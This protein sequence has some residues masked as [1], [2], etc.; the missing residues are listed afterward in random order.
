MLNHLPLIFWRRCVFCSQDFKNIAGVCTDTY[1]IVQELRQSKNFSFT[2]RIIKIP[3]GWTSSIMVELGMILDRFVQKW[4]LNQFR[5][6]KHTVYFSSGDAEEVYLICSVIPEE[7]YVSIAFTG[8]RSENYNGLLT[9]ALKGL[10]HRFIS[11][12]LQDNDLNS[13]SAE[14]MIQCLE[15]TPFLEELNI[16]NNCFFPDNLQQLTPALY[17][18]HNL[19]DLNISG[20]IIHVR[21]AR[22]LAPALSYMTGLLRLNMSGTC[23]GHISLNIISKSIM[24]MTK[25]EYLNLSS[26]WTGE[27]S[28]DDFA[29]MLQSLPALTD[30]DLSY[31]EIG[32]EKMNVLSP[33]ICNGLTKLKRLNLSCN[34][35]GKYFETPNSVLTISTLEFLN[36]SLNNISSKG[37]SSLA[38]SLETMT[39][40]KELNLRSNVGTEGCV[41][42]SSPIKKMKMLTTLDI[43]YNIESDLTPLILSL[44]SLPSLTSLNMSCNE[45]MS[46][47]H[48]LR[49]L[50]NLLSLNISDNNLGE[51]GATDLS[52]PLSNMTRLTSLDLTS[53]VIFDN[54][55]I[56]LLETISS[57]ERLETIRL[58]CCGLTN[59]SAISLGNHFQL[60]TSLQMLDLSNNKIKKSGYDFLESRLCRQECCLQLIK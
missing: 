55:L 4:N 17:M 30:L 46:D 8:R 34:E 54:G 48:A 29:L 1:R 45:R 44:Y 38:K 9:N 56:S 22:T 49:G 58:A 12:N 60:M 24:C 13:S 16:S 11:L 31:S 27:D 14:S 19:T 26:N 36:I 35:L 25:L 39:S 42:L 7:F 47:I 2:T 28:K 40:L 57:L 52:L 18:L 51:E 20:N 5:S 32:S 37:A 59:E 3:S 6:V 43:G 21:N 53:N 33:I 10:G 23:M 41:L 50:S 15:H